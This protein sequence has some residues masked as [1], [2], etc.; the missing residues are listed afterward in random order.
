MRVL[1]LH[2][3]YQQYGGEDAVVKNE[4]ALLKSGGHEVELLLVSN[5]TIRNGATAARAALGVIYS[6]TGKKLVAEAIERFAPDVVHV[7]NHFPLLSPSIFDATSAAGV[8]SVW[9]L[10]NFRVTCANGLL[11][12][13]GRPCED[14]VG[15]SSV[16]G[17][18]HRCYRNSLPASAILSASISWHMNRG[19]WA[20]KVSRFIALNEFARAKFVA[21]GLPSD[22]LVVK[23]NFAPDPGPS[24]P[25]PRSGFIYVGRLS[26]EKGVRTLVEAWRSVDATLTIFGEGPELR[27][28]REAAPRNVIFAGHQDRFTVKAALTRAAALIIPSIWYENFPMTLVDAFAAGTPVIASRRGA[29][30]SLVDHGVTGLLFEAAS[31]EALAET[32]R[33]TMLRSQELDAMGQAARRYYLQNLAPDCNLRQLENIYRDARLNRPTQ[34]SLDES[35]TSG[36]R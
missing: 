1:L 23:P 26:K 14:C 9:T 20:N 2:N 15:R 32:V 35:S 8:P 7:H 28:L 30:E 10:H 29:L 19:T 22:R 6:P 11:F 25:Y 31:A 21:A 5:D 17:L 12:R 18:I 33:E 16:S 27:A 4:Q 36:M 24:R 34:L 3:A 13:D